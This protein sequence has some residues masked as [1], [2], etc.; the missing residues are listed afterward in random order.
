MGKNR[1][2]VGGVMEMN[3]LCPEQSARCTGTFPNTQYLSW[4]ARS[5]LNR[6]V[7]ILTL[8]AT[9]PVTYPGLPL[10]NSYCLDSFPA[11]TA[12]G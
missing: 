2:G 11:E 1:V 5:V 9:T 7:C 3:G 12:F 6:L 4:V 10:L 8:P